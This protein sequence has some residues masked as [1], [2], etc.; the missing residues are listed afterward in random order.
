M[1]QTE[2]TR[3]IMLAATKMTEIEPGIFKH[4]NCSEVFDT[5]DPRET[6]ERAIEYIELCSFDMGRE[7][8]IKAAMDAVANID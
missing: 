4:E 6:I 7:D 5:E 8:G 2:L 1:T 3:A